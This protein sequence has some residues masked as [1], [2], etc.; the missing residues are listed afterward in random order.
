MEAEVA[1][2]EQSLALMGVDYSRA[3]GSGPSRDKLPDGA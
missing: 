1:E 2:H 3:P